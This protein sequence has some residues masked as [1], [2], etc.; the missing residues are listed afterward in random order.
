MESGEGPDAGQE[1]DTAA[2]P[3]KY[4]WQNKRT[5]RLFSFPHPST[6]NNYIAGA[7]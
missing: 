3:T 2:D 6:F 1:Q 7:V 5:G 4:L